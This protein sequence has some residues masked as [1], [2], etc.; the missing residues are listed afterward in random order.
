M[1]FIESKNSHYD[2]EKSDIVQS[3]C[4]LKLIINP[5][6]LIINLPEVAKE[7]CELIKTV[8]ELEE[9]SEIPIGLPFELTDTYLE[10][11]ELSYDE[12]GE[13]TEEELS[14]W[15]ELKSFLGYY[16]SGEKYENEMKE[17]RKVISEYKESGVWNEGT[18]AGAALGGYLECLKYAR[19]NGCPW[20]ENTCKNAA[21]YGHLDCLKYAHENG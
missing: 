19:E 16:E 13:L 1:E 3:E 2:E 17:L 4:E 10:K 9:V 15:L 8:L 21:E 6:G 20:N 12:L 14:K 7:E 5:S 18:C 11:Y